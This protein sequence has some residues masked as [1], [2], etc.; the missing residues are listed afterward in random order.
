MAITTPQGIDLQA[1][2]PLE[3]KTVQL[4]LADR[5]A[6]SLVTRYEGLT[7]Y[8]AQ[9]RLNYQLQGGIGNGF[10]EPFGNVLDVTNYYTKTE[11]QTPGSSEVNWLNLAD[12]PLTFV[13]SAH[14]H[15]EAD[16]IDL[17]DYLLNI[18]SESIND[19]QDVTIVTPQPNDVLQYIGGVWVNSAIAPIAWGNITG[20]IVDQFDLQNELNNKK[21]DFIENT[22][23]NKDFGTDA[24]TVAEGNHIHNNMLLLDQTTPQSVINGA[25]VFEALDFDLTPSISIPTEGRLQWNPIDG[26]LNVGMSG[27]NVTGQM[28]LEQ[29]SRVKNTTG[30]TIPNGSVVYYSGMSGERPLI[31]LAI[32]SSEPTSRIQGMTTQDILDRAEG[33]ITTS[34]IVHEI[35]TDYTGTGVWGTTWVTGDRL[36]LS[37]SEL[38]G[39]TNIKPTSPSHSDIIGEVGTVGSVGIGTILVSIFRHQTLITL[40]DVNDTGLTTTGQIVAWN[41]SSQ[42][43]EFTQNINARE[44]S[45]T[46]SVANTVW[47][48]TKTFS[49]VVEADITLSANTINDVSTAKHG[50]MSQLP[51]TTTLF[52]RGDGAFAAPASVAVPNGYLQ[53]SFSYTA[54]VAHNITHNFGAYPTWAVYDSSGDHLVPMTVHN[55]SANTIAFTFSDSA[56]YTIVLSI[57]APQLQHFTSTAINYTALV[58]DRIISVTASGKTITL[59]T[60]AVSNTGYEY[61]ID[62]SSTGNITVVGQGGELIQGLVSQ[63]IA[64]DSC[65]SIYSNGVGWRFN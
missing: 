23:F 46:G 11:L 39:V 17:Q 28:F 33:Y 62:N 57:G 59:P 27:G 22:G 20:L 58:T 35:K 29:F 15:V 2:E 48:G 13:P 40:S 16:I 65:M 53:E 54:T 44:P 45:I 19:L 32:A 41:N 43:F 51:G 52:Y 36:Y 4:T 42:C 38:G 31:S 63:V 37:S 9:T 8:V 49:A 56:T 10:W 34:G 25:P 55:V 60:A 21:N 30:V 18:N 12:V 47:H 64:P 14:T 50:F 1:P 7:V 24:N 3:L 26:T 5:D 61:K 6:I